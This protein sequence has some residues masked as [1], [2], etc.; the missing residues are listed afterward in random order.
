MSQQTHRADPRLLN[1]RT[2]EGDHRQL[3]KRLQPGMA[4]LD[5][6][7]GTGAITAGIATRVGLKGEVLGIDRDEVLLATAR[8]EHHCIPN[9]K[10]EKGD[11]LSLDFKNRFDIVTAARTLQWISEPDL[12][13]QRMIQATRPGGLVLILD[14]DHQNNTWDP[15]PPDEFKRFYTA[16][17]DWRAANRWSNQMGTELP[18]LFRSAGLMDV[19][20]H[21]DDETKGRGDLTWAH[22]IES[23]GPT[24]VTSGFLTGA[25]DQC[26]TAAYGDYVRHRLKTQTLSLRTVQGR[27]IASPDGPSTA[28]L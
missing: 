14:Y 13:I 19:Q 18:G 26:A 20:S 4:V 3:A 8:R 1:R 6:G 27:Q 21:V 23:L 25:E 9:L 28:V 24:L 11:A 16:F 22:V 10:F 17:L 7:C 2:L 15:E 12:A 5:V